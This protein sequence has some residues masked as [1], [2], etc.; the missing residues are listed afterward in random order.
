MKED[1]G[2]AQ[3]AAPIFPAVT[4]FAG[5]RSRIL[6]PHIEKRGPVA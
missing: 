6:G 5:R 4:Y 1:T 2:E 3:L